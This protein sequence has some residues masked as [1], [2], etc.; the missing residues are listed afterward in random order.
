MR[1]QPAITY[2]KL[3]IGTLEQRF[4]ICSKLT[5]PPKRR[6][7]RRF[8]GFIVNLRRFGGFIV[9]FEHISNLCSSVSI[10]NFEQ[11]NAGCEVSVLAVSLACIFLH[12][13]WIWRDTPYSVRM[14]ENTTRKTTNTICPSA[15]WTSCMYLKLVIMVSLLST[16]DKMFL[17]ADEDIPTT[18]DWFWLYY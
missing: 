6:R 3:T 14:Q 16:T 12:F 9:N 5:K 17:Y 11:V 1:T 4:E 10:V 7:W 8:G 2:S 13:Y 18:A 15:G